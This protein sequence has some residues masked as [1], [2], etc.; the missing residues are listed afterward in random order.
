[1][2]SAFE[3]VTV[4]ISIILGLGITQI[5]TAIADLIHQS[6]RVKIYWPHLLWVLIVLILHVQEW[7]VTYDLKNYAPWRLPTFLFIMVYPIILFVLARLLFPFGIQNGIIDLKVFYHENHRK[8]FLFSIGLGLLA[9]LDSLLI[10]GDSLQSQL[11]KG[12]VP[13]TFSTL[14]FIKSPEWVH[15][16]VAV[17]FFL[18]LIVTIAVQ[19]NE[20]LISN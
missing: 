5:L 4:L 2:I 7:W 14:Y 16:S 3:Y 10:R 18:L 19:W 11:L 9:I 12:I 13:L 6:K 17:S 1:M 8:I 15:K 20:W